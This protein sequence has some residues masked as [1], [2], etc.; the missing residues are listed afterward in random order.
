[1]AEATS[2][3]VAYGDGIGPELMDA[4]LLILKE[5]KARINIQTV[6]IGERLYKQGFTSGISSG[7][8]ETISKNKVFLK[9]PITTPQGN[10]YKSFNL[11]VRKLL[12]LYSNVCA[13]KTFHPYVKTHHPSMDIVVIRDNEEDLSAG[14]EYRQTHNAY[15]AIKLITR[16]G[17]ENVIRYAFDY[18]VKNNRKKVTCMSKDNILKFTDGLFR[19]VFDE[20][21]TK[22]PN[23]END[24]YI[25][26]TGIARVTSRPEEFDVIVTENLYGDILSNIAAEISGSVGMIGSASIGKT[27]A[28]FEAIH[29][30]A[31]NLA[32]QNTANP[33]GLLNAAIMMLSHIGQPEIAAL[34]ENALLKTIED[35]MHTKDIYLKNISTKKLGTQEFAQ[36]IVARLGQKPK[37]LQPVAYKLQKSVKKTKPASV[38]ISTKEKKQLVGID[39]FINLLSSSP[40]EVANKV[41]TIADKEL[42]LQL[43]SVKGLKIWP[44]YENLN[45]EIHSDHWRLRFVPNNKEKITSHTEIIYLLDKLNKNGLEFVKSE[46]LY[47]FNGKLGFSLAQEK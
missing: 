20:I 44:G 41:T 24:Y 40:E 39:I 23:I 4:V 32:E 27:H 26:D 42:R 29:G 35:G 30:S 13:V 28:M 19:K 10:E 45:R 22:Y 17:C 12:G 2:I 8:W 38:S 25:V 47:L 43:I 11:T 33:S 46:N 3:T 6:E 16:V 7:A 34:I 18:A 15:H 5:A 9:A 31:P 1:M 36:A 14:I 37:K 21:A